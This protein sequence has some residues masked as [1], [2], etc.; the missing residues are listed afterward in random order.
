[1]CMQTER[2]RETKKKS[3]V[4]AENRQRSKCRKSHFMYSTLSG[5]R[6]NNDPSEVGCGACVCGIHSFL[7]YDA[8]VHTGQVM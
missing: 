5:S 6:K 4:F 2:G 3:F 1:M 7:T 8:E